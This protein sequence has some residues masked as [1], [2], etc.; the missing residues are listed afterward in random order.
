MNNP[1]K[2]NQPQLFHC[3]TCG[4]SLPNPETA[5]VRC[6]YCGSTVVAPPEML[7][8]KE[9]PRPAN[10]FRVDDAPVVIHTEVF[11]N[12]TR[13][14]EPFGAVNMIGLVI[15][16][17]VA[18][19]VL[20]ALGIGLFTAFSASTTASSVI[21]QTE[22][23]QPTDRP[24]ATPTPQPSPT[25]IPP[26]N[27]VLQ[28][29]GEG[30]GPG[31]F[32]DPRSIAVD[33]EGYIFVADYNTGRLQKFD[34]SGKFLQLIKLDPPSNNSD[35]IFDLAT[36]YLGY[37]YVARGADIL[38][39]DGRDGSLVNTIDFQ[40]TR[41]LFRKIAIDP[42]NLIYAVVGGSTPTD[43]LIQMSLDGQIAWE[44]EG[45]LYNRDPK[46]PG[47]PEVLVVDGLGTTFV[48]DTTNKRIYKFNP[49]GQF[50]DQF[51]EGGNQENQLL[52]PTG[53]A[54]DPK[55]RL[56]VGDSRMIK[57]FSSTGS[58]IRAVEFANELGGIRDLTIDLQGKLY[59]V[60]N[61]NLV[62]VFEVRLD[63]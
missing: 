12:T 2:P 38:V 10:V 33:M 60:T 40:S 18:C 28:F 43:N 14:K 36:D 57:V 7:P 42:S 54:I 11:T 25:P 3:P 21:I 19:G 53:L 27:L 52:V 31:M 62:L 15:G 30:V 55:G 56:Y 34:S 5:T 39:I 59:A 24:T 45:F 8:K 46:R 50:V 44:N 37:L 1:S 4:A 61:R 17:L 26:I 51:G 20:V 13:K 29:G 6:Q 47:R 35:L 16:L 41:R 32:D 49:Q 63:E 58:F 9:S 23:V 48:L 22:V